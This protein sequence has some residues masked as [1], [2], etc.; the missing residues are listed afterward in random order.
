MPQYFAE[1][2]TKICSEIVLV[3]D[4]LKSSYYRPIDGLRGMAILLVVIYHFGINHFTRQFHIYFGGRIGVNLFFV[5]SGFL[6]TTLLIKEKIK[7]D[8]ISMRYFFIR[9]ILRIVPV[10]YLFLIVIIV[11][12]YFYNFKISTLDFIS[13]FLF[14]KNLPIKGSGNLL[15]AHLWSLAIEQ[16]FYFTFPFLLAANINRYFITALSIVII[17][18]LLSIFGFYY[19]GFY[20]LNYFVQLVIRI[21]MYAFW[22]GPVMILIG[23]VFSILVFKEIIKTERVGKT[24]FAGACLFILA[25]VIQST[26]FIYYHKYI[27]E[28]LSVLLLGYCTVL[29]VKTDDLF[30][31][32]LKS[33]FLVSIGIISYSIYIW[34]ELFIGLRPWEPWLSFWR[35]YPLYLFTILKLACM[36]TIAF[37]SFYFYESKFLKLKKRFK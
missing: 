6:I 35:G 21:M 12:N 28:Y 15:T 2:K 30:A 37:I 25:I 14:L 18:P 36:V 23:S 20:H 29:S 4:V 11:L 33:R 26:T 16:Q 9:R 13:S 32:I 5:I 7:T 1:I 17:V 24:Y 22:N 27:S 31:S 8:K 10:V 34:Q 19:T 3:P